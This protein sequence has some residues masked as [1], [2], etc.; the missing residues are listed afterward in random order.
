MLTFSVAHTLVQEAGFI[1][2]VLGTLDTYFTSFEGKSEFLSNQYMILNRKFPKNSKLH[3]IRLDFTINGTFSP[4]IVMMM[5]R[6]IFLFSV[7]L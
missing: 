4:S 2:I 5:I 3:L 1:C 6:K 7:N